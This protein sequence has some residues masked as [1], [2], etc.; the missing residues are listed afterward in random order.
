MKVIGAV[1]PGSGSEGNSRR[2]SGHREATVEENESVCDLPVLLTTCPAVS[3][4]RPGFPSKQRN[5]EVLM[6]SP[7]SVVITATERR[8]GAGHRLPLL[9][10]A[11]CL[12]RS[13][14]TE[15]GLFA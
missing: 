13:N 2:P 10:S 1:V 9:R 6:G 12:K 7:Q 15:S 4:D 8:A 11:S 3:Q 5:R 14:M